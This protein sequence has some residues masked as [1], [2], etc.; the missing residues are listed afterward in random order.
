MKRIA[1]F[2][3]VSFGQFKE[4]WMDEFPNVPEEEIFKIYEELR[5]PNGRRQV[6]RDMIFS[7][8]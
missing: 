1:K 2:H 3:K 4:G 5:L 6:R 8:R 7:H